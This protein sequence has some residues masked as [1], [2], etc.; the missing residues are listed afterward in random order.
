MNGWGQRGNTRFSGKVGFWAVIG[1]MM[2]A[3]LFLTACAFSTSGVSA[4][5]LMGSAG[6]ASS[7]MDLPSGFIVVDVSHS[8]VQEVPE[9]GLVALG[10][11]PIPEGPSLFEKELVLEETIP[12]AEIAP[13]E[14]TA[15]EP[16]LWNDYYVKPGETLSDIAASFGVP[17]GLIQEVNKIENPHKLSEGQELLIPVDEAAVVTVK[18]EFEKRVA[19]DVASKTVDRDLELKQYSVREG[20]SL[21]SIAHAFDLDINTL[22]GCNNMKDPNYLR[23]G[24]VLRIPNQDGVFYKVGKNDTL[25]AIAKKY[26][27]QAELVARINGLEGTDIQAGCELFLPGAKPTTSVYAVLG[28]S[29]YKGSQKFSKLFEWPLRGGITSGYGWRRDPFNK[30]RSFHTGIDIKGPVGRVIR[31]AKSGKV[32]YAGWMGGFGRVI[33]ID[34]G[35]GYN[36]L[37]GHC[38]SL[39]VKK[40]QRVTTGQPIG[41]VGSS[42]RATGSHLHFEVR[43]NNKPINPLQVLK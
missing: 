3:A 6:K 10:I 26:G 1:T 42:G 29:S 34:H 31:A 11:G 12:E 24:A 16:N 32:V 22:F 23:V 37:Y 4:P 28:D 9:E 5:S 17:M 27:T 33:V 13:Q 41:K 19:V 25:E 35:R 14:E 43:L 38:R 7:I 18:E 30:R 40:G 2:S 15:E 8:L 21:W 20:D 36:T 39:D